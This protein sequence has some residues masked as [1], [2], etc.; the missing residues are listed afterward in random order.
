MI[1]AEHIAPNI[2]K[3]IAPETLQADDFLDLAPMVDSLMKHKGSIRLLID[4]SKLNG[5]ASTNSV[6]K[7]IMFVKAHQ[8]Q[9]ERIA[10]IARHD[11]QHWFVSAIRV[12]LHPEV[13]VFDKAHEVESLGWLST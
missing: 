9:V 4:A 11:W 7:H 12:F 13:K 3:I 8:H 1:K 6:E 10:V 5:W 2:W